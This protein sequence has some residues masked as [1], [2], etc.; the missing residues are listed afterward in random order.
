[1]AEVGKINTQFLVGGK[2][3]VLRIGIARW[4]TG[5]IINHIDRLLIALESVINNEYND[6]GYSS[7][8]IQHI[9]RLVPR[10]LYTLAVQ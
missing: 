5:D 7:P 8:K 3:Q 9:Y 10:S 2:I 6:V 4:I 1:M